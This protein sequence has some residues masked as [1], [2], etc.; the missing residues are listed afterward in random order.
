MISYFTRNILGPNTPRNETLL[1]PIQ[2]TVYLFDIETGQRE[3]P[4]R[5]YICSG[6]TSRGKSLN[7]VKNV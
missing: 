7:S 4:D 3:G 2:R 6:N 1:Q 5:Q